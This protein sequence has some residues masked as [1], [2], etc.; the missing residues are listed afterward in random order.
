MTSAVSIKAQTSS[1]QQTLQETTLT[2]CTYALVPELA[3]VLAESPA[4]VP[5]QCGAWE[6]GPRE[7][8]AALVVNASLDDPDRANLDVKMSRK[9][10]PE[11]A[12]VVHLREALN[13]IQHGA[14]L[15]EEDSFLNGRRYSSCSFLWAGWRN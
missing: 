8:H 1:E 10:K 4:A 9:V 14:C 15:Y 11:V 7:H 12:R 3:G 6:H 13:D 5:W 2:S